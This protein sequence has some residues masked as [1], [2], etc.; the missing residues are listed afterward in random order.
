MKIGTDDGDELNVKRV[1]IFFDS[2][3]DIQSFRR[4]TDSN[5]NISCDSNMKSPA[6]IGYDSAYTTHK[7]DWP[8]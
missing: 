4:G 6:C 3:I 8:R 1:G 5:F 2:S 7:D